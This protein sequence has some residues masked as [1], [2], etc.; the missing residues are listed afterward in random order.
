MSYFLVFK[1][2][3]VD[4]DVKDF[5]SETWSLF[6]AGKKL[7]ETVRLYIDRAKVLG[8]LI[9]KFSIHIHIIMHNN[10]YS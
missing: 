7:Q 6:E 2:V 3:R 5:L 10:L 9:L 4:E 8:Y 1:M